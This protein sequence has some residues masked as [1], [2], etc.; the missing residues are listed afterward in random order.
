MLKAQEVIGGGVGVG[1]EVHSKIIQC[2]PTI[3]TSVSARVHTHPAT[4]PRKHMIL[5]V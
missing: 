4:I 3:F 5:P 2:L 1:E